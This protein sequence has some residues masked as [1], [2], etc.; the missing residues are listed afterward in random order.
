MNSASGSQDIPV[1]IDPNA[2]T[3]VLRNGVP[4]LIPRQQQSQSLQ[5]VSQQ[6]ARLELEAPQ[7]QINLPV[8]TSIDK[9]A[10][11]NAL[12][13]HYAG[14]EAGNSQCSIGNLM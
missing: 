2:W 3:V 6:P 10:Y 12:A 1:N 4:T 14:Q 5:L 11:E 8:S 7:N 13:L 9:T